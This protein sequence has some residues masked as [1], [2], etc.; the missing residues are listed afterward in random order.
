MSKE[1]AALSVATAKM[2]IDSTRKRGGSSGNGMPQTAPTL[3]KEYYA[4]LTEDLDVAT[5]PLTGATTA[6]VRLIRYTDRIL[7]E[8]ELVPGDGGVLTVVNRCTEIEYE[9]GTLVII[10]D[11]NGEWLVAGSN[12]GPDSVLITLLNA[13]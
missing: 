12:C 9:R 7:R 5:H 3:Q 6:Q 13:L 10:R 8:M 4:V 2:L 11:M 1:Y